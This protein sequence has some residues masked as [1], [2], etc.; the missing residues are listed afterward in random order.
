MSWTQSTAATLPDTI[1]PDTAATTRTFREL[2]RVT[3]SRPVVSEDGQ[4]P[5][6]STGT[7]VHAWSSGTVCEVEFTK[8]FRAIATIRAT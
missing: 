3:L 2:S 1:S 4:V 6:E 8:P 5:A 7:V